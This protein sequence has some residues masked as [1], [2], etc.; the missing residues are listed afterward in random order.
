MY[1]DHWLWRI[2]DK[3]IHFKSNH[4]NLM[5]HIQRIDEVISMR[6][7][8]NISVYIYMCVCV[9]VCVYTN[10]L[11]LVRPDNKYIRTKNVDH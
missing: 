1:M 3:Y 9:C 2:L 6:T 11:L 7:D 5:V 8:L 10:F 4:L